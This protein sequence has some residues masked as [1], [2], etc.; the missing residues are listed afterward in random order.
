MCHKIG[1]SAEKRTERGRGRSRPPSKD[2]KTRHCD[3]E[4]KTERNLHRLDYHK[5]ARCKKKHSEI[6]LQCRGYRVL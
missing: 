2:K 3:K 5:T 6:N 1:T 4:N